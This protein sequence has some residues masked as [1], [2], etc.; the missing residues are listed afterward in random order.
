MQTLPGKAVLAFSQIL[1]ERLEAYGE[2][3]LLHEDSDVEHRVVPGERG[4]IL[5][6]RSGL[7]LLH[8]AEYDRIEMLALDLFGA[9]VREP[10]P[11]RVPVRAGSNGR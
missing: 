2:V 5:Q 6:S 9:K 10:A 3:V 4:W 8:E 11:C 7:G 1:R